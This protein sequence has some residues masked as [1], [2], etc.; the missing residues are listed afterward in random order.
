MSIVRIKEL[1]ATLNE[2]NRAYYQEDR[3]IISNLEYDN[4]YDE[5]VRLEKETGVRLAGSPTRKVGYEVVSN[6]KKSPHDVPMLSLD[7]T[8]EPEALSAFLGE[9]NGLLSWKLDGL[10]VVLKYDDGELQQALTRGNGYI[11]EDITHNA[12]VF[13][14]V[15]L[16]VPYK[17]KFDLRGEAVI[18]IA[19]FE[20]INELEENKYKNPRNLCSGAVRQLNSETAAKRRV[21]FFAFSLKTDEVFEKKSEQL[22]W[23]DAQGFEIAE[24]EIV[25]A[26]NVAQAVAKFKE[27]ITA[28]SV[29]S[30]GLVLTY[31]DIAYSE[32]LGSTSKF[33]RDSVAFKWADEIAET[34]LIKVEWGTSRTGLINPVAIFEPVEIEGTQVSRASLHNVSILRGLGLCEGDR[35]SVYK[36][37]MIIPQVAENLSRSD[38]YENI[39][40]PSNCPVC[41]GETEI[42]QSSPDDPE[43]LY[44]TNP[45]CDAQQVRAL[46]HFVS[47][48]ALNIGGLSEQT[49]E[50]LIGGGMITDFGDLFSLAKFENEIKKMEGFGQKSYD[51]L[52]NSIETA[53][54]VELPNFIYALGIRH[55]GLANAK[56]LC[57]F[58]KHD[59]QEI[60]EACKNESYME[61]LSEIKGFG[62]AISHSLHVYFSQEK[63]FNLFSRTLE[64]LRIKTPAESAGE[65]PL[66]GLT[67]VITGDVTQF[68]NRK[69]LQT[70]IENAGGRVTNSVTAKTSFLINNDAHSSS[71]KNKKAAQLGVPVITEADLCDKIE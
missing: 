51:N 41:N 30:D 13:R 6:L 64:I 49:L 44:C 60:T 55:V 10:T 32:S 46:A 45:S 42:R 28:A 70:Y 54:D 36:A 48:D 14:N 69:E 19:D 37:N 63:N 11:G 50:K 68:K 34:T 67:F 2:A 56:L 53:K 59:A 61:T 26:K 23:L 17:G 9:Y 66:D 4:L 8:K 71:S 43:T 21:L 35:I 20:D 18:S 52:I 7:K 12:R 15:P 25:T 33:P 62:E 16:T 3:E 29:M 58:F 5:L 27:K 39:L 47:R 1:V 31:D 57:K 65:K 40:I 24:Y 22:A 38:A